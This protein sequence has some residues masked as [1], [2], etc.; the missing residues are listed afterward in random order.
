MGVFGKLKILVAIK[1][2]D[3]FLDGWAGT[4]DTSPGWNLSNMELQQ[5]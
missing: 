1:D 4:T 5:P 3:N 2:P